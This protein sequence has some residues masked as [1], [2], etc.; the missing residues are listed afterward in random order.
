LP[1][2]VR[3]RGLS[4]YVAVIFGAMSL[5]SAIWGK[6][7]TFTGVPIACM[8]AAVGAALSV[9]ILMRW[10]LQTAATLD[11]TPSM[12]LPA[13]LLYSGGIGAPM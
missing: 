7:A 11:L 5:G 1:P 12:L 4:I 9:P 3:G 13:V 2:W 10:K 6:A 8:I